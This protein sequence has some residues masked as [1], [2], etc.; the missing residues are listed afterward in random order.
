MRRYATW[1]GIL[2]GTLAMTG[3]ASA[4]GVR[5]ESSVGAGTVYV[6]DT[7][8]LTIAVHNAETQTPPEIRGIPGLTVE[9]QSAS[10]NS[11]MS[12]ING[13]QSSDVSQNLLYA[14]TPSRAGTYIIPQQTVLVD[15]KS[16]VTNQVQIRAIEP[17]VSDLSPLTIEPERS[18]VFVGEPVR[19]TATWRIG[20]DIS[21]FRFV[22][23]GGD[24]VDWVS[25]PQPP[26]SR[27]APPVR[28][29]GDTVT[30]VL[31]NLT[32]SEG[33]FNSLTAER[34]FI[35]LAP[36]EV[37]IGP[38]TAAYDVQ[39]GSRGRGL[40]RPTQTER[41]MTRSNTV[42]VRALPLPADG[43]PADFTGLVGGYSAAASAAPLRVRVGDPITLTYEIRSAGP[44]GPVGPPD[45]ESDPGVAESFK[46]D[47]EGWHEVPTGNSGARRFTTTIRALRDSISEIPPMGF[48]YFDTGA[49]DY[50]RAESD[51]I[52]IR[53]ESAVEVTAAD[54]IGGG[55]FTPGAAAP[56]RR[57]LGAGPGGILANATG[58]SALVNRQTL[59]L[60]RFESPVWVA[61][62]T[63]PPIGYLALLGVITYRRTSDPASRR[64]SSARRA[65]LSALRSSGDC[66]RAIRT[67][68]SMRFDTSAEAL[69]EADCRRLL[70]P[71]DKPIGDE[72][73]ALML[74]GSSARYGDG[75]RNTGI[76]QSRV[77]ELLRTIDREAS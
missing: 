4:Q 56:V 62:F 43:K 58:P 9:Y 18:A 73:A 65:A 44:M 23:S 66:E 69:T 64:R 52:P 37:V 47:P 21:G 35:P 5:V 11:T 55:G 67:Y 32:T 61:V 20:E 70:S 50:R 63:A 76:D 2:L 7:A 27:N 10:T 31:G 1:I 34:W 41:R 49:G 26:A 59:L 28:W 38:V 33:V 45:L 57:E 51:S 29:D 30:G 14:V 74:A 40:F 39:T 15:G 42:T 36:G 53:V 54:A 19:L 16:Y 22:T 71:I 17:P 12:W 75:A 8:T 24:G 72:L 48:A 25:G 13:R 3:A 60:D 46:L 6:G 77:E 68:L